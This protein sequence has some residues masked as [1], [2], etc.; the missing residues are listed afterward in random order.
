[1]SPGFDQNFKELVRERTSIVELV[2][3]SIPLI[4]NGRDFKAICPFH[5]DHNPSMFIYPER[6]TWR[7]WSCSTGGDCFSWVEKY[8]DVNFFEALKILAEKAHLEVPQAISRGAHTSQSNVVEKTSLFEVMKWA[9][10]QFH[11]CLMETPQGEVARRYLMEER[12]YTEETIK[13]FRLGFHPNDWQWLVNRAQGKYSETIL[14]EARLTFKKEGQTRYSD[15][16][17]N[18]VMFPVRDERKRIVAFG[19]RIL[20]GA[21]SDKIAKYFNS[22]ESLIFTKSK[23][24][25]GLDESRQR[26]RETETVV[27][28][29]GYTDCITAHQFG[30]TNVVA[31]L[32]TALTESHVSYLKRLA[33]KVVLVFDGDNAG[34]QAA[35]RS[36]IKF[37][38]QEVDLRILTLPSGKDPADFLEEEGADT[39]KQMIDQAPEAWNYKLQICLKKFGL[40][41]IDGQHRILEE[42]L[43]LIAAS[44]NLTGKIRED[45][46]LRK[47]AD[48]LGLHESVVRKRLSEV[49]Q[50]KTTN[51]NTSF[52][53]SN[54]HSIPDTND[55]PDHIPATDTTTKDN[56]LE[57]EL[58]EIIFVYPESVPQIHQHISPENLKNLQLRFIY[59]LSIDL[60]EEGILPE[61]NR[62][63]DRIHDPELKQLVVKIDAHA[64]EKAIHAKLHS[65]PNPHEGIP[66]FLKHSINNL[67]WREEQDLHER[68]KGLL[69]ENS[70]NSSLTSDAK[71][72]LKQASEYH[73][74]RHKKLT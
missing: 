34:Q 42:M 25:F 48:R 65:S 38:S 9:E 16:F 69:F 41:S 32:G 5:N 37:I 39:L 54:S 58:L 2:S 21:A 36:L 74:K 11:S 14:A 73:Q 7:C 45:I 17:V 3:E 67:K 8:D 51:L 46:I 64:H 26:I 68:K 6:G 61:M 13:Q 29:E 30:V 19:G 70:S 10:Q 44:P 4:P 66:H 55:S 56:Q 24:L 53:S 60:T 50:K 31:T 62:I 71:E 28:V 47:L 49:K 57:S 22:S 33:R 18:R 59:Q 15:Y 20:P 27:V 72:L 40:E 23:L 52:S 1:M 35:E 12:G 63:L 43:E